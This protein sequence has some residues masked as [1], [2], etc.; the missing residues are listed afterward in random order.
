MVL[1]YEFLFLFSLFALPMLFS[2]NLPITNINKEQHNL[3]GKD[4][5]N[6]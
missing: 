6:D 4:L 1:S 3:E 5:E 2:S